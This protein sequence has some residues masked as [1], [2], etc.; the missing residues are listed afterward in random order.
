MQADL[1]AAFAAC[2]IAAAAHEGRRSV[3]G[4]RL[5]WQATLQA[6]GS[7]IPL[8]L[9]DSWEYSGHYVRQAEDGSGAYYLILWKRP[10]S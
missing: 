10:R 7:E 9:P 3:G 1:N 8:T 2:E 4:Y 6:V 5:D